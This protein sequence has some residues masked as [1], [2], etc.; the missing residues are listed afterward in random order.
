MKNLQTFEQ[1]L[2][3]GT[4]PQFKKLIKRAKEIGI[5]TF[6]ELDDLIGDEFP[7]DI[8]GAD[9][10]TARKM[11]KLEESVVLESSE[12][13]YM[14]IFWVGDRDYD[15]DV[16]AKSPEDAINKVKSGDVKGP[17]DQELPKFAKAFKAVLNP[18]KY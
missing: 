3:E 2:N 12:K 1:F 5:E 9:Y 8:T 16:M 14:V 15:W 13:N 7:E 10:E 17:G 11:L 18:K 4:T 6:S